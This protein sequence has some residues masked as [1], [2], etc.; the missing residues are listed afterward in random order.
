MLYHRRLKLESKEKQATSAL[1]G[2]PTDVT[3]DAV[4]ALID[5][6]ETLGQA[7]GFRQ[8]LPILDEHFKYDA[9]T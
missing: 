8:L 3:W 4:E 9:R 6:P 5:G 7:D 1:V 2:S